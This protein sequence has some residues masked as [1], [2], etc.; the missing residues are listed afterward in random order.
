MAVS[1]TAVNRSTSELCHVPGVSDIN[2]S[3]SDLQHRDLMIELP[4][5]PKAT[6]RRCFT[7]EYKHKTALVRRMGASSLCKLDITKVDIG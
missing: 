6:V 3:N 4:Q 2:V 5:V 1:H 7:Q